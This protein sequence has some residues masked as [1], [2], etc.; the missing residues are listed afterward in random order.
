MPERSDPTFCSVT[1]YGTIES[2]VT[3]VGLVELRLRLVIVTLA[4]SS[5]FWHLVAITVPF[6]LSC[7]HNSVEADGI[8]VPPPG[9]L[10]D[11]TAELETVQVPFGSTPA[12]LPHSTAL[13]PRI[14]LATFTSFWT[15]E[16]WTVTPARL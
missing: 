2:I 10:F 5:V 8:R 11:T 7:K 13:V 14:R 3:E 16:A 4:R 15:T 9:R 6:T 1:V 12:P